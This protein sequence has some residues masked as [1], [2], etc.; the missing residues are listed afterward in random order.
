MSVRSFL[1]SC[2]LGGWWLG[3]PTPT[4]FFT[5]KKPETTIEKQCVAL[6]E[7]GT[8]PMHSKSKISP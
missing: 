7:E 8:G 2:V 5:D 3:A 1:A 6:N 4:G